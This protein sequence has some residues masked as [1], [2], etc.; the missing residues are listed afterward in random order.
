MDRSID[1]AA[2][3]RFSSIFKLEVGASARLGGLLKNQAWSPQL[4]L[5]PDVGNLTVARQQVRDGGGTL[6]NR[7][8]PG[9]PDPIGRTVTI[10]LR[11]SFQAPVET[12]RPDRTG[13]RLV[14]VGLARRLFPVPADRS[15]AQLSRF[16]QS[17]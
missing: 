12:A 13:S 3:L 1:P 11:K 2:D 14:T 8:Q 17:S 5:S 4:R 16:R 6:P 9:Y 15:R 10:T 7:V